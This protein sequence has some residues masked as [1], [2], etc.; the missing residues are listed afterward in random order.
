MGTF[1]DLEGYGQ[2]FDPDKP[3]EGEKALRKRHTWSERLSFYGGNALLLPPIAFSYFVVGGEG[4]RQLLGVLGTKVYRTPLPGAGALKNFDGWDRLDVAQIFA[5]VLFI[6]ILMTWKVVF[7]ESMGNGKYWQQ[8]K[9]NPVLVYLLLGLVSVLLIADLV[10]FYAGLESKMTGS[11]S[12]S[13]SGALPALA[14]ILYAAIQALLGFWHADYA[15]SG[16]V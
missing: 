12:V 10:I 3:V 2:A 6:L 13:D 5:A 7:A 1:E 16:K 4:L 14:A 9:D 15:D 8:R 11:W